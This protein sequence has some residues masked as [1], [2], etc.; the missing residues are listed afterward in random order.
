MFSCSVCIA[1]AAA[2]ILQ[3]QL[4]ALSDDG[5]DDGSNGEYRDNSDGYDANSEWHKKFKQL[6]LIQC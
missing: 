3:P 1:P 4:L 2:D 5:K 6:S